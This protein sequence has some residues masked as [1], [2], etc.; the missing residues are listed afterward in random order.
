[1]DS[2]TRAKLHD[3]TL[4][5]RTLLT[6][7]AS[8]LLEGVYGMSRT[9]ALGMGENLPAIQNLPEARHTF[10]RLRKYLSDEYAAGL[11]PEEAR[12]KLLK[13]V[14]F[15]W[16]NRLVAFKMLEGRKLVRGTVDRLHD[17]NAF[18]FYL[19][20]H[21]D[22]M[23]LYESGDAPQDAL[24][25]GPRDVAYRHFLLW[26][27]AQMAGQIK[28]LFDP[29]NLPSLL[30]PR[31]RA[32]RALINLLNDP[33]L[34]EAWQPGNEETIGWVYQY[35]NEL[36]KAEVFAR[37]NKGAKVSAAD[38]PA[39]TQLF[40]PRW[41]VRALVHNS[42]GR[43]WMQMHPDSRLAEKLDYLVPIEDA[44]R[45]PVR[46]VSA[47]T[48]LD[49]ACGTM[50]FGLVAFDLF[51]EMYREEMEHAGEPG[52]PAVASVRSADAIPAAIVANNLFGIDIDLRAVQ[53][54]ALTLLLKA[55]SLNPSCELT[56][57]NLASA[58]VLLLNGTRLN[59]FIAEASFTRPIYERLVRGLWEHLK[60]AS[61][62]GSLLRLETALSSL[63]QGERSKFEA[64]RQTPHL[65]GFA[66]EQFE[67]EAGEQEF[68]DIIQEQVAQAFDEFAR[69]RA[70]EGNDESYFSG[71]AAKGL[72]VLRIMLR[73][74]DVVATN[75]PYI[76][77]RDYNPVM[78]S[79][80][81]RQFP[82][83]KRNFSAAFAERCV[84]LLAPG[85]RLAII[86]GQS[87]MFIS[88]FEKFR[89]QLLQN[90][91]I[92]YL[93]QY[94][95]GL[96]AEARV[97]TAAYV[98]RREPLPAR[99]D[100]S[101]GT[102]FRLVKETDTEA[103]RRGF[104]RALASI[105]RGETDKRVYRYR[106][107]DF[108]AIPGAPW[109]YW[110]T[111]GLRELFRALP[112]LEDTTFIV[113]GSK[114]YNNVRFL[115]FW[116]EAG[117]DNVCRNADSWKSF[118]LSRRSYVPYM[119][120]GPFRRWY[121]NQE[122]TLQLLQGGK[123]LI[124]W[125][126]T[127][128]DYIRAPQHIFRRG[129]TWTDLTS[130]R[131]GAR[132]S[133]GGFIFD[134]KGS[135]AFPDSIPLVLALLNSSFAQFSL[136]LL[137]P[138]VSFQVGDI[139]RLPTPRTSSAI[140]EGLVAEAITLAR[141]DSE[142]AETT[143]DY[144]SPPNWRTGL[145]DVAARKQRVAEI[146]AQ[147]DEEVYRLYGITAQDRAA[148]E[149]E[150]RAPTPIAEGV[151]P[152]EAV[153]ES[154]T[155]VDIEGDSA[156]ALTKQELA[157][158]WVS[159][160]VG[161]VMGRFEPGKEGALGCGRFSP[162]VAERLCA[163]VDDDGIMVLDPAHP[164]DLTTRVVQVLEAIYGEQDAE[165][166]VRAAT[167]GKLLADYFKG[168]FFKRH[169]Q[170]YRKRPIYWLLQSPKKGYSLYVFHEKLTRDR[171]FL[172]SSDRYLGGKINAVRT[173]V[174]ELRAAIT[175]EPNGSQRKRLEREL[176]AKENLLLDLE[177]FARNL[178]A[179]TGATNSQ[180]Q[181]VG[182]QPEIDDGVLLN[183]APMYSLMP[184]WSAEPKKA[185]E[186]LQRGDYDWS[187]T[188]MRYWP[189]RVREKCKTNKSYAIAHGLLGA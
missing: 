172:I 66:A 114:T 19:A 28:V 175:R 58:D 96:F 121:G 127:N 5:A 42:L 29:T 16:L 53:L 124:E 6:T 159:Y 27:C 87:F 67:T 85:G 51:A 166:I 40:T 60:N 9:G 148:I 37:L 31:P 25:E 110:I 107:G 89:Q 138:T 35:F 189:D 182:W 2:S 115:R 169:V 57:S 73:K 183:L 180:G 15:T 90:C 136:S 50:H 134:V 162:E 154:D 54:S 108:A 123:V 176:D 63:V 174:Q 118:E 92:E 71:E 39:A 82:V 113:M 84:E 43:L 86:T 149:E 49:P 111:P 164:D 128:K 78:K 100:A 102:Y 68:W 88:S 4:Q 12:N 142:E 65:P 77:S 103:K 83:S 11:K 109:V 152:P 8:E 48:M 45:E 13:E 173:E 55:K 179:V 188:A 143:Y 69:R 104:E 79:A 64:E 137:N 153:A 186:A 129:V 18:K 81:E 26:Q 22:E 132:L 101:V 76:D 41:I 46:S 95:Y 99:R 133:P 157:Q 120:G 135:S 93:A 187:H 94:D 7:E 20:D 75:P 72:R 34:A 91:A 116:W 119:K 146:E 33:T 106:Q 184:S 38:I 177:A 56:D 61:Q 52:W 125:L 105:R 30:F 156:N 160:A 1:M 151:D 168:D 126:A 24:G 171:L 17:S 80:I 44:P 36:E 59:S 155:E 117:L 163:L 165:E 130:G 140:L 167:G 62:L 3:L 144:V 145:E 112:R 141:S 47:I 74:Y 122:Y 161:V 70:Q 98:L 32:L 147:L 178:D 97:D 181:P 150:L 10:E 139:S 23:Q 158:R 170:Q 21:P 14:A 185:W 131:F